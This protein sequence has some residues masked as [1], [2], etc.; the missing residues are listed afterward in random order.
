[1]YTH[2]ESTL[3]I[4]K[5]NTIKAMVKYENVGGNRY[6]LHRSQNDHRFVTCEFAGMC[7]FYV[8]GFESE[9]SCEHKE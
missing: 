3:Y 2:R 4:E 7:C 5:D 6:L 9:F 8:W 1:M